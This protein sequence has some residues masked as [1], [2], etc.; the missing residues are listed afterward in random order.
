MIEIFAG[1]GGVGKTTCA[2][3]TALH[4]ASSG[5][6]TLAISTDATPSLS[7]MFGVAAA[8]KTTRVQ[9]S[10]YINELGLDELKEMW[11][12][13]FGRDVYEVFSSFVSIEYQEFLEFMTSLL[14]GLAEEFMVD[15]IRELSAK[16]TYETIV[17]DTAPLGQT[18]ALLRTP[19]MLAEHLKMAPRV[20]SRLRRGKESRESVME[21]LKRWQALSEK[22]LAFLRNETEFTIVT[23]PETLAVRQLEGVFAELGRNGFKV[24]QLVVNN[25]IGE[26]NSDFLVAKAREQTSH[27]RHI[28]ERFARVRIVEVPMFPH[29]ISGVQRLK[30]VER[31]LFR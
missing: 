21:V 20:Y 19:A 26:S 2:S 6:R 17:W 25:V 1:K 3:A 8:E 9:Q 10:L 5:E 11:D 7:H 13:R 23:I 12:T 22:N 18:L 16:G 29:E 30:E 4:H 24:K 28:H 15:F 27:I 14:P 31:V